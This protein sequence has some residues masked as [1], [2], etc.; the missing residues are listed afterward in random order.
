M[1]PGIA[2]EIVALLVSPVHA[3]EGRP[4]DGPRPDPGPVSHRSVTVRAGLGLVGDR[5][6]GHAAHRRAAVTV[7]D[8]D[9]LD[10]VAAEI[11]APGP[12]DPLLARRNIVL[13]GFPVDTLA[14]RR[15][16]GG[17]TVAGAVFSL[18]S[19]DGPVRLRAHRPASPCRWMDVRLGPGAWKAMRG[20][21]GVR[22][23]PLDDGTLRLGRAVL[24]VAPPVRV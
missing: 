17:A 3:Y 15:A 5:F 21:G 14:T 23:E 11:R 24:R 4:Q 13:R 10:D 7:L 9:A 8:A 6:F 1:E 22:C 20:R 2:V 12:L 18:D 16:T 19:G